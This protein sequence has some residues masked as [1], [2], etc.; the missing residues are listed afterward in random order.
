MCRLVHPSATVDIVDVIDP[1]I[2]VDIV[3]VDVDIDMAVAA[4]STMVTPASAPSGAQ[5]EAGPKRKPRSR[6]VCWIDIGRIRINGRA[7]NDHRIVGWDVN[8]IRLG[9]LNHDH[10]FAA[11]D[12]L[13]FD[14]LLGVGHQS[15][16]SL[17]L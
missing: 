3:V 16:R 5:D 7:V 8:H 17:G 1:I 4:P 12:D 14:F 11:I 9:L 13:G 15:A 10:L 6:H 2:M